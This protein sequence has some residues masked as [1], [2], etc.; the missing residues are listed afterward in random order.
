MEHYRLILAF[1]IIAIISW[2]AGILYL[3]RLLVYATEKG[4]AN[5]EIHQLLSLMARRLYRYITMP[6][7]VV[8]WALGLTMV[9]INPALASGGWFHVKLLSVILLTGSSHYA[10][11]LVKNYETKSKELPP[12]R[13]IR[14]LNEVPTLLMIIIVMMVILKPF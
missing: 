1:H 11:R 3:Y 12:S 4:T 9:F 14:F 10:G 5:Q 7:M 13:R 2:M 8:S 6:A